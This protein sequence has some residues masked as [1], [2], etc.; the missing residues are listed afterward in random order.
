MALNI[1]LADLRWWFRAGSLLSILAAVAGWPH[2]L[3]P[4]AR[5]PVSLLFL[6]GTARVTFSGRCAVMLVLMRMPWNAGREIRLN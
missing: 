1:K 6:T 2:G 4:Q 5:W 3:W